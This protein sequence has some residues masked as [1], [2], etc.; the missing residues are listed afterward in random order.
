MG[1]K[2][3]QNAGEALNP[4]QVYVRL[5]GEGTDVTRPTLAQEIGGGM[6]KLFPTPDYDTD[7]ESW[8]FVPGSMVRAEERTDNAG[9]TY[10]LAVKL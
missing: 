4:T 10:L 9:Q 8:E 3:E 5:L 7:G 2:T 6:Y 1:K